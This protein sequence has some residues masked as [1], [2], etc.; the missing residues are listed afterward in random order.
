VVGIEQMK[1]LPFRVD[2]M[3]QIWQR[4]C[5]NLDGLKG[6]QPMI[7]HEKVWVVK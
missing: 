4:Y 7:R 1:K 5:G 3:R 6:L 2:R